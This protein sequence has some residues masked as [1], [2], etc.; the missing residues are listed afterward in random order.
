MAG[1]LPGS[2]AFA[3]FNIGKDMALSIQLQNIGSVAA[4]GATTSIMNAVDIG[5][6][7]SYSCDP[8]NSVVE[9]DPINLGG[10]PVVRAVEKG[11]QGR[12]SIARTSSAGDVLAQ[13]FQ[14]SYYGGN[15]TVL[16]QITHVIFD[17][18]G[19]AY[20]STTL[21]YP[22]SVIRMVKGGDFTGEAK[23]TQEFEFRCPRR[24]SVTDTTTDVTSQA[25]LALQA[26]IAVALPSSPNV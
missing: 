13:L 7:E 16:A 4:K 17:P 8:V 3:A 11:W 2:Q 6:L 22:N 15:G 5:I 21:Q 26:A 9:T 14:E 18:Q 24:E 25:L 23:V 1:L 19:Y 20:G 12:F 10:V